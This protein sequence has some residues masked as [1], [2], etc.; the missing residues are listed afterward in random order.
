MASLARSSQTKDNTCLFGVKSRKSVCLGERLTWV[1]TPALAF[2]SCVTSA[3]LFN[4]SESQ[5]VK[6]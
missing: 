2:S 1:Q 5:F 3:K 6:L 4:F